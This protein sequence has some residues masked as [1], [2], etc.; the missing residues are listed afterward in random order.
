MALYTR[1]VITPVEDISSGRSLS[2]SSRPRRRDNA[3]FTT[4]RSNLPSNKSVQVSFASPARHPPLQRAGISDKG[5]GHNKNNPG[6]VVADLSARTA[7]FVQN[8]RALPFEQNQLG[9]H[10]HNQY[11]SSN[12]DHVFVPSS[13]SYAEDSEGPLSERLRLEQEVTKDGIEKVSQAQILERLP[14]TKEDSEKFDETETLG[15][16]SPAKDVPDPDFSSKRGSGNTESYY[17]EQTDSDNDQDLGVESDGDRLGRPHDRKPKLNNQELRSMASFAKAQGIDLMKQIEEQ[18]RRQIEGEQEPVDIAK[19]EME[20]MKKILQERRRSSD[21]YFVPTDTEG[22]SSPERDSKMKDYSFDRQLQKVSPESEVN[23][24]DLIKI[25]NP[26][27]VLDWLRAADDS[28]NNIVVSEYRILSLLQAIKEGSA[29][30]VSGSSPGLQDDW[31][32]MERLREAER[33]SSASEEQIRQFEGLLNA[34]EDSGNDEQLRSVLSR[35]KTMERHFHHLKKFADDR[36]SELKKL[37]SLQ[38][39]DTLKTWRPY[40]GVTGVSPEKIRKDFQEH[41]HHKKRLMQVY[42]VYN[43]LLK[44]LKI[45]HSK[46]VEAENRNQHLTSQIKRQTAT[47]RKA[48]KVIKQS[49]LSPLMPAEPYL[50]RH[51]M[52]SPSP[53]PSGM[54]TPR[55]ESYLVQP[56]PFMRDHPSEAGEGDHDH[57]VHLDSENRGVPTLQ[58]IKTPVRSNI[59]AATPSPHQTVTKQLTYDLALEQALS[60]NPSPE[61]GTVLSNSN[62]IAQN[63]KKEFE[64]LERALIDEGK[65]RGF[66]D[67]DLYSEKKVVGR[68]ETC[69]EYR[70]VHLDFIRPDQPRSAS[71]STSQGL[72]TLNLHSLNTLPIS[73][74]TAS[75][76]RSDGVIFEENHSHPSTKFGSSRSVAGTDHGP[77]EFCPLEI[78]ADEHHRHQQQIKHG[79][80]SFNPMRSTSAK[81]QESETSKKQIKVYRR[82]QSFPAKIADSFHSK[83]CHDPSDVTSHAAVGTL[84]VESCDDETHDALDEMWVDVAKEELWSDAVREEDWADT[85]DAHSDDVTKIKQ[86]KKD[87]MALRGSDIDNQKKGGDYPSSRDPSVDAQRGQSAPDGNR[88]FDLRQRIAAVECGHAAQRLREQV[89]RRRWLLALQV[90]LLMVALLWSA[91][92]RGSVPPPT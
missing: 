33:R 75:P 68:E 17:N 90:F 87:D 11:V 82:I 55:M 14:P 3:P 81:E 71:P 19:A 86:T 48:E 47:L 64:E 1:R 30:I 88:A 4:S 63:H 13:V 53:M 43:E 41:E 69:W 49:A 46:R 73:K 70:H 28:S 76:S 44:F 31:V 79:P 85:A 57:F 35:S 5:P 20:E 40:S 54:H 7:P 32:P 78:V 27:T 77:R 66:A 56:S 15:R 26:S 18:K 62:L 36:H 38:D 29:G 58:R 84:E 9:A 65:S 45:E 51:E 10:K 83:I 91:T 25:E 42:S 6:H 34:V 60:R 61:P 22:D 72:E 12:R 8:H 80:S 92:W 23:Q 21:E 50:F 39:K 16:R 89:K 37:H 24:F 67:V 74:R 2:P 52:R 59:I